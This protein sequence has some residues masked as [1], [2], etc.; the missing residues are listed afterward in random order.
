M[1]KI[2]YFFLIAFVLMPVTIYAVEPIITEPSQIVNIF[3]NVAKWLYTAFFIIAIIYVLLAAFQFLRGGD[4]P[5][6]VESAKQRLTYA[7]IAIVI[8]LV[9]SGISV[10][11]EKFLV[12]FSQ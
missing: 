1:K 5:K 9:A 10:L 7:V 4:N 11:I 2:I 12:S 6:N 3:E 8:A